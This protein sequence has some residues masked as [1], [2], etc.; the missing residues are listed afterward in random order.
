MRKSK[1]QVTLFIALGLLILLVIA[2]FLVYTNRSSET[3][4]E[5]EQS[6]ETPIE[7]QPIKNHVEDCLKSTSL[8]GVSLIS[9]QGGHIFTKGTELDTYYGNI[10]YGY[11]YGKNILP[12]L[13]EM[14]LDISK[15]ISLALPNCMD[16][17]LFSNFEISPGEIKVKTKIIGEGVIVDVTYPISAVS[18]SYRGNLDEFMYTVPIRLGYFYSIANIIVEKTIEDSYNIDI[19]YLSSVPDLNISFIPLSS[20]SLVYTIKDTKVGLDGSVPLF[21]FANSFNV[22]KPPKI[23][24][25]DT[26]FVDDGTN[27][28]IRVKAVDPDGDR[29]SYYDDTALFDI[30]SEGV[31][32]FVAEVVGEYDVVIRVEDE[33]GGYDE[34]NV[35]F[36]IR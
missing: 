9:G 7:L 1:G 32:S 19:S 29:V 20:D 23:S 2:I 13:E 30:S 14:E 21:M 26:F 5:V 25:L 24:L 27:F 12:T 3:Q 22:N 8:L 11:Y 28:S 34:A 10:S 4:E 35:K 17:S 15:F 16:F 6:F 33:H 18:G 36:V 31:I